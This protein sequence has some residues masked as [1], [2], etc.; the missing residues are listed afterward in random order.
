MAGVRPRL[1]LPDE[2]VRR[3]CLVFYEISMFRCE[4]R[5]KVDVGQ[6]GVLR[7]FILPQIW[8]EN[9]MIPKPHGF[10]SLTETFV[11]S[12]SGVVSTAWSRASPRFVRSCKVEQHLH[13]VGRAPRVSGSPR[14][15]CAFPHRALGWA[16]RH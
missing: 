4:Y 15:S 6:L 8:G 5:F 3:G 2:E 9:H 16:H 7:S 11:R 1:V 10:R 13:T 12:S 14:V